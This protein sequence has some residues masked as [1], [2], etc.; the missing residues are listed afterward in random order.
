MVYLTVTPSAQLYNH[1]VKYRLTIL[2][3]Q[4]NIHKQSYSVYNSTMKID[5]PCISEAIHCKSGFQTFEQLRM[6]INPRGH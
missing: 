3:Q 4:I 1:K 2:S 5:S 6:R